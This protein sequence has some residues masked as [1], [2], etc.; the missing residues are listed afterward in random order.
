MDIYFC[1]N[2]V[3]CRILITVLSCLTYAASNKGLKYF[4]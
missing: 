2:L 3:A 4:Y 1:L